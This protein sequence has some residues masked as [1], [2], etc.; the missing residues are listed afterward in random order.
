[1]ATYLILNLVFL[2]AIV[3]SLGLT[4]RRPHK[5]WW[6]T[7]GV[8]VLLTAVFDSIIVGL[9]IVAYNPDKILGITIGKAPIEDFFYALSASIIVPTLWNK[10][11][12]KKRTRNK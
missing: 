3:M 9:D 6:F 1:M 12:F 11:T 7:I 2:V 8:C 10:L 4:W 5:A